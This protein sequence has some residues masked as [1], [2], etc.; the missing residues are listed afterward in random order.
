VKTSWTRFGYPA[1][2]FS[3]AELRFGIHGGDIETSLMLHFRPD[4][5]DISA[6]G[7]FRSVAED[8]TKTN[9]YVGPT[10]THSFAWIATDLNAAGVV[11]DAAAATAD[12]GQKAAKHQARGF[13][14]LLHDA[15]R[16]PAPA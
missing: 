6:A 15:R 1:G 7:S 8:M 4:L 11:G 14:E 12:K 16:T 2:L 3:D 13:V 5:V 10:G 9:R